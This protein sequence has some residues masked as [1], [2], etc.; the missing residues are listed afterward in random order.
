M[1]LY[2]ILMGDEKYMEKC[3]LASSLY[4]LGSYHTCNGGGHSLRERKKIIEMGKAF[5]KYT[6]EEIKDLIDFYN[7]T[8]ENNEK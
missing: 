8:K 3:Y 7:F 2:I 5:E 1:I 4:R 6:Q